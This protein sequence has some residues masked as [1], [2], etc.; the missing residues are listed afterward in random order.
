M[1]YNPTDFKEKQM[2]SCIHFC[3]N[4]DW[5]LSNCPIQAEFVEYL[6]GETHFF[7][8]VVSKKN[9]YKDGT[10]AY[11]DRM[12]PE[13]REAIPDEVIEQLRRASK[14]KGL[15]EMGVFRNSYASGKACLASD[16]VDTEKLQNMVRDI[17]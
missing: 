11:L 1:K 3:L 4:R 17:T 16:H 5:P 2:K 15:V 12:K 6:K 13:E 8:L 7:A 9:H 14:Q 10:D